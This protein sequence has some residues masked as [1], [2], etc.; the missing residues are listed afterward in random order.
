[1]W[2]KEL[3]EEI[4]KLKCDRDIWQKRAEDF[5][6]NPKNNIIVYLKNNKVLIFEGADD[7]ETDDDYTEI[8]KEHLIV[9]SVLTSEIL[10]IALIG[11]TVNDAETKLWTMF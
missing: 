4:E 7:Y 2:N 6:K 5:K 10:A 9:G 1:M 11:L 3:K 8:W